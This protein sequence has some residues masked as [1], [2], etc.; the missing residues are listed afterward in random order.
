L[1]AADPRVL[2]FGEDIE[3][4]KGGVFG[5]TKGLSS[6]FPGRVV[7]SP[8]AEATIAGTACGLALAGML[9]I[10]ELQFID[11]AGPAFNQL[12][13]QIATLRW[14]SMGAF[15][16]PMVIVAPCGAYL[17][18]GGPWHS[19]TGESWYAHA[20]GLQIVMPSTPQDA[21][22]LLRCACAGEDPVLYLAPKHLFRKRV[23]S[24]DELPVHIG[25]ACVRREGTEVTVAAWGN[26]VEIAMT[27]AADLGS[28]G[29]SVEV[30]DLR[31]IVP[32]DGEAIRRSLAKTGRLVVVQED[33]RTCSFGQ[34][35][36][37]E[38]TSREDCWRLLAGPPQ[39]VS[40]E[41]VHIG[42]HP[43]LEAA[44]MPDADAVRRAVELVI[45]Y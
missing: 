7:N 6:A 12:V 36:V 19:Q 9:P 32:C 30:V 11:F 22:A 24:T 25:E 27:A 20:P 37:A 29:V 21:A 26:S 8:L 5:L 2:L 39:L 10:I 45:R 42:F 34:A 43:K 38:M 14:R 3:D 4:G 15:Q 17:P 41:D 40:R 33:S 23:R 18:A 28:R 16:C 1:L 31:S 44:T 13:N 35:I